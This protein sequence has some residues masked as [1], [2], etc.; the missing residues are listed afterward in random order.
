M[1]GATFGCVILELCVGA[2]GFSSSRRETAAFSICFF[3][4][5]INTP[6]ER[7]NE[8]RY[9]YADIICWKWRG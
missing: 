8:R 2:K 6:T 9:L 7:N 1:A 5:Y 4:P 3:S